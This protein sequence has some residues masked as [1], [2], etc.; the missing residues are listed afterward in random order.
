MRVVA[1][2][3]DLHIL[4]LFGRQQCFQLTKLIYATRSEIAAI[5]DQDDVF[6]IAEIRE[7]DFPSADIFELE[8]GGERPRLDAIE[9]GEARIVSGRGGLRRCGRR[10]GSFFATVLAACENHQDDEKYER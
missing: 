7:F 6:L 5:K 3:Q 10:V 8:V 2:R 1:D 9:I 4:L